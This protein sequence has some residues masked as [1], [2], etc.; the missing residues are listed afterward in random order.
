MFQV[1]AMAPER[2]RPVLLLWTWDALGGRVGRRGAVDREGALR[3]AVAVEMIH[4]YSLI[5]DDLPAMDDSDLRR[6][7]S[8]TSFDLKTGD[9]RWKFET[10]DMVEAPPLVVDGRVFIGSSDFFFYAL[11][12]AGGGL[13]WKHE[14][15]DRILGGALSRLDETDAMSFLLEHL[16]RS[17]A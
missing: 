10:K 17:A 12:A 16:D 9:Q 15:Q 2:L 8:V 5:H 14:T 7:P 11:D 13:L 4:T 1:I 3:A 6:A